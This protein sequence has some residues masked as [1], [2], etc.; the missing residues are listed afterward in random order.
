MF[1]T[2]ICLNLS[3]TILFIGC[4]YK[5]LYV[6]IIC[7]LCLRYGSTTRLNATLKTRHGSAVAAARDPLLVSSNCLVDASRLT[8]SSNRLRMY[9]HPELSNLTYVLFKKYMHKCI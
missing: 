2:N 7:R 4:I 1:K 5:Y 8:V 6:C 9:L 3:Y